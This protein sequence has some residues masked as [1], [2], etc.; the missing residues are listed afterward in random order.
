MIAV[1]NI[2]KTYCGTETKAGAEAL[3]GISFDIPRGA[4]RCIALG[5]SGCGKS[6]LIN[7]IAGFL[8]PTSG[9]VR[10]KGRIVTGPSPERIVVFQD[11]NLLPWKTAVDNISLGLLS[12]FSDRKARISC[13]QHYIDMMHLN[14]FEGHYPYQLSGGMRQRV[15][16][17]RALAVTPDCILMDEPLG[18]LDS[19]TRE[20]L[21]IELATL[22]QATGQTVLMVTHDIDEALF[23]SQQVIVL[24]PRPTKIKK[25]VNVDISYPRTLAI[26]TSEK[27][28]RIKKIVLQEL[29]SDE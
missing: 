26:K 4:F 11:H 21:Q 9:A 29:R 13:A 5:P 1:E 22:W 6:T 3:A 16:L 15:A 28:Q 19:L 25:I 17:A 8:A 27:F 18:A 23:L 12:R 24:G 2:A 20:K 7:I 14:G 10:C